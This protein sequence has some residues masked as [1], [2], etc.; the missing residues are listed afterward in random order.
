[1]RKLLGAI[2]ICTL[3]ANNTF[4]AGAWI[5]VD[6]EI[7]GVTPR[8]GSTNMFIVETTGGSG[9]CAGSKIY[10]PLNFQLR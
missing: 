4:A 6:T 10:F 3:N 8:N 9:S 5:A 2:F 1:M 7:T